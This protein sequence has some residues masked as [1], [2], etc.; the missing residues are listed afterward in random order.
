MPLICVR[1]VFFPGVGL[2]SYGHHHIGLVYV[3]GFDSTSAE[4]NAVRSDDHKQTGTAVRLGAWLERL[5]PSL[6][7][8]CLLF[9]RPRSGLETIPVPP[10]VVA[11][12]MFPTTV[13]NLRG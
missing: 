11:S 2:L 9:S 3:Q 7:H 1:A 13:L 8:N 5:V 10:R 6:G 4:H 12:S